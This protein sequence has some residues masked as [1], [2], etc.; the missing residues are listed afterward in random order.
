M[1]RKQYGGNVVMKKGIFFNSKWVEINMF[2]Y[3]IWTD[4][5]SLICEKNKIYIIQVCL[6]SVFT[7][8]QNTTVQ[9]IQCAS[10]TGHQGF[11][12]RSLCST[13]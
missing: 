11:P 1:P 10:E 13:C 4:V 8:L 6:Q 5:P 9:L 7:K 3:L 12:Q 2:I